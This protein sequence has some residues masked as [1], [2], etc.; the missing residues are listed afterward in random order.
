MILLRKDNKITKDDS[1]V[2]RVCHKFL[3]LIEKSL[4]QDELK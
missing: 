4:V 2:E 1:N 3:I